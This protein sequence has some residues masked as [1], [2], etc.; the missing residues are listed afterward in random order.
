LTERR[1]LDLNCD[2]RVLDRHPI[3][4]ELRL[5]TTD[6]LRASSPPFVVQLLETIEAVS[7]VAHHLAGL[8]DIAKLVSAAVAKI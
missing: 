6:L 5:L 7:A 3:F 4:V 8:A 2:D 1:L